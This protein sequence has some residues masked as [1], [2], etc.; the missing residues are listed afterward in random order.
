[1]TA[2]EKSHRVWS[3]PTLLAASTLIGLAAAL[4]GNG[5]GL[6]VWWVAL[7]IPLAIAGY[8][9]ARG[10]QDHLRKRRR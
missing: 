6:G 2:M 1:M 3:M 9:I 10:R 7:G 8:H 4:L 5:L